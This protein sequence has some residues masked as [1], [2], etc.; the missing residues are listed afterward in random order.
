MRGVRRRRL[1]IAPGG[2]FLLV[3]LLS[4]LLW[5]LPDWLQTGQRLVSHRAMATP[6]AEKRARTGQKLEVVLGTSSKWRRGL[7]QKNFPEYGSDFMA[8][9]IDEKA[10]RA[11]RPE[12]MTVAIARAKADA[13]L[14]RL[15][16]R[17]VLL[18]CMDQ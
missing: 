18:V 9:D 1:L 8:A 15:E 13:L 3:W 5:L 11:E 10:I 4:L 16:G 7:F 14:P 2:L 12:D 17:P 6:S